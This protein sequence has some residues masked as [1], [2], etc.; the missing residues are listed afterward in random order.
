[1]AHY[2]LHVW[3]NSEHSLSR[4]SILY[5]CETLIVSGRKSGGVREVATFVE[6]AICDGIGADTFLERMSGWL[7]NDGYEDEGC[8]DP[9]E[10]AL[11]VLFEIV[12]STSIMIPYLLRHKTIQTVI[13]LG[14][15]HSQ[16]RTP[17]ASPLF[18]RNAFMLFK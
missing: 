11:D 16:S 4:F 14:N 15:R 18:Y 3:V 10:A 1:M 9:L 17:K 6:D 13:E 2:A 7:L 5:D 8:L 12:A